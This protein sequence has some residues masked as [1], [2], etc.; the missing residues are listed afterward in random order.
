MLHQYLIKQVL[1][2]F[3]NN[4]QFFENNFENLFTRYNDLLFRKNINTT[5]IIDQNKYLSGEIVEVNKK[6][7]VKIKKSNGE[8]EDFIENEIKMKI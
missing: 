7:I 2:I 3:K 6:G 1:K 4:F 8:Y 5:F